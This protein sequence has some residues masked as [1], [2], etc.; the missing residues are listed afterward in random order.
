MRRQRR[1]IT[2]VTAITVTTAM[3]S[4]GSMQRQRRVDAAIIRTHGPCGLHPR[5]TSMRALCALPPCTTRV[6]GIPST[7][8]YC[9]AK[10][11]AVA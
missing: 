6:L 9:R 1:A 4:E 7:V 10:Q 3:L 5:T 2:G 11:A 8:V